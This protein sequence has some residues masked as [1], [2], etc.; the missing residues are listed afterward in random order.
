MVIEC[1][2]IIISSA[3]SP[4][5]IMRFMSSP[6]TRS[7]C[8]ACVNCVQG[9]KLFF[10]LLGNGSYCLLTHSHNTSD[11][12]P[13]D[14]NTGD[15]VDIG[16]S[17]ANAVDIGDT[18][19]PD[20]ADTRIKRENR[21]ENQAE[22]QQ[23]QL[24]A[25]LPQDLTNEAKKQNKKDVTISKAKTDQPMNGVKDIAVRTKILAPSPRPLKRVLF[26]QTQPTAHE[27]TPTDIFNNPAFIFL[28]LYH[29]SS[30]G[31]PPVDTPLLLPT[32]EAVERAVKVLDH[33]PPYNTHKIGVVYV[34]EDQV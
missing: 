28:Q 32:S 21:S 14:I 9:S 22:Q 17:D 24:D 10:M 29:S 16:S 6:L 23:Q 1:H 7:V 20:K 27:D 4:F 26:S 34:G 13:T 18:K 5:D 11:V 25:T 12:N 30:L 2:Y 3:N 19:E 33:I 8:L 15:P 31:G